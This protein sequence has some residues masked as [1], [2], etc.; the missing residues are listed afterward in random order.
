MAFISGPCHSK[1]KA[2]IFLEQPENSGPCL[3]GGVVGS[4]VALGLTGR[5]SGA[6]AAFPGNDLTPR[7]TL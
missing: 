7:D 3:V 6:S 4:E 5:D 2:L 1:E